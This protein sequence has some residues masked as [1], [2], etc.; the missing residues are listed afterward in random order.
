MKN[1]ESIF[2][3]H[4]KNVN[5][6]NLHKYNPIT[7]STRED[8]SNIQNI[9]IYG[10]R[11]IGKYSQALKIIELYSKSKLK[12]ERK[13]TFLFNK[14]EYTFPLSDIH[15]EVDFSLLGCASKLL[16][17]DIY[18]NYIDI[19]LSKPDKNGFILCKNF[20][21]IHIELHDVFFSY[22]SNYNEHLNIKFII[23]TENISF[24]NSD[25]LNRCN[26]I[27]LS[28]PSKSDVNKSIKLN[29]NQNNIHYYNDDFHY[30]ICDKI[31]NYI[32][33]L[34]TFNINNLRELLYELLIYNLRISTCIWYIMKEIFKTGNYDKHITEVSLKSV[35]FF[36]YYNNNYRPIYHL[37][38]F[39]VYLINTIHGFK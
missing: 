15:V 22:I 13:L 11:G 2:E 16:W 4:V 25:I 39:F 34:D 38:N 6:Y 28:R 7:S 36:H 30:K 18:N 27:N 26:I 17:H 23:L 10:A 3:S 5:N 37:E 8:F 21:D 31:V 12:Y 29:I 33:N 9:I 24:L 19:V 20:D 14:E 32:I 1:V 35:S